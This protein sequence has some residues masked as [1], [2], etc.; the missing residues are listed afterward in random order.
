MDGADLTIMR[1]EAMEVICRG[2]CILNVLGFPFT[3]L[4]L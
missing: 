3:D 4:I 1:D 2:M